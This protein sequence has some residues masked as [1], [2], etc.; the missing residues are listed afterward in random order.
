MIEEAAINVS[1]INLEFSNTKYCRTVFNAL[2]DPDFSL[3]PAMTGYQFFGLKKKMNFTRLGNYDIC[4]FVRVEISIKSQL[5]VKLRYWQDT[6][7]RNSVKFR[8]DFT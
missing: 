7:S 1:G 3:Y 6:C 5:D 8:A 4:S 2:S